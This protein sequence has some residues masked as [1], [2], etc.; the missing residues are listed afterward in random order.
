M[1][2]GLAGG[3]L[4]CVAPPL[5]LS[6]Q[7][8]YTV[9][10]FAPSSSKVVVEQFGL[11]VSFVHSPY[12]ICRELFLAPC[13]FFCILLLEE[14]FVQV[15]ALSQGFQAPACS[16]SPRPQLQSL[17]FHWEVRD[18]DGGPVSRLL[19]APSAEWLPASL[20]F[21]DL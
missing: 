4:R 13:T 5:V 1:S 12:C 14:T 10:C 16:M 18:W 2:R 19:A 8:A 9:P 7:E 17:Q 11:F 20:W 15:Q 6:R 3:W 21:Q